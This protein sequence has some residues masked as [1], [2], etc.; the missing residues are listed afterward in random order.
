MDKFSL[1]VVYFVLVF[2]PAVFG[3]CAT[4]VVTP[5]E[6][7]EGFRRGEAAYLRGEYIEASG[8][9]SDYVGRQTNPAAV[10]EGL[11]WQGM[12][13]LARKEFAAAAELFEK[14]LSQKAAEKWVTACALSGLGTALMGSGKYEL[15]ADVFNRAL[16]TGGDEAIR[17]EILFCLGLCFQRTGQWEKAEGAFSRI[18]KEM[19]DSQF[20]E[21]ALEQIDYGKE[22]AFCVQ[23]GAYESEQA[24]TKRVAELNQMGLEAYVKKIVRAGKPL[25]CARI[26]RFSDWSE[27]NL[28]LHRLRGMERIDDAIVKP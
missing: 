3:G 24:A 23:V 2:L 4:V 1:C 13:H 6:H 21:R 16:E 14:S 20:A 19:P 7:D 12:C 25:Y 8:A 26:G 18:L 17:D 22:K 28:Q 27:A 5:V 9:F 15:A 10:A 11:Y